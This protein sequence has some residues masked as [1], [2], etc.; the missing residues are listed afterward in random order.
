MPPPAYVWSLCTFLMKMPTPP[1]TASPSLQAGYRGIDTAAVYK[2][3]RGVAEGMK[4]SGVPRAEIFLTTKLAPA[5]QGYAP[6]KAAFALALQELATEY[7][8]LYLIHWPGT[9]GKAP[10][11]EAQR[12][13]RMESWKALEELH[14]EGKARY[15]GISK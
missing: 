10:E 4:A 12:A 11:D 2:N 8:D 3:H 15:I 9:G 6:A 14:R 7:V 5:D 1:A 13:N